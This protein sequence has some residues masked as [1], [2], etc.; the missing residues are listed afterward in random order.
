[1]LIYTPTSDTTED[2]LKQ[3]G[4]L[5]ASNVMI[6]SYLELKGKSYNDFTE[7]NLST[8]F[9]IDKLKLEPIDIPQYAL[10]VSLG[11]TPEQIAEHIRE[12]R[13]DNL[14]IRKQARDS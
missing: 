1:M 4:I 9:N 8:R 3:Y 10:L 6:W 2:L 7:F 13:N 11:F 5:P 14:H 12:S